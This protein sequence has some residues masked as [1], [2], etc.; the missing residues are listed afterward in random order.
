MK[1]LRVWV[2]LRLLVPL[3]VVIVAPAVV[4]GL[5]GGWLTGLDYAHGFV[6]SLLVAWQSM[7]V[8]EARLL[9]LVALLMGGGAVLVG[10]ERRRW[11]LGAAVTMIVAVAILR[12]LTWWTVPL[13]AALFALNVAPVARVT[14]WGTRGRVLAWIP[15]T[16]LLSPGLV[17][18]A[19]GAGPRLLRVAGALGGLVVAGLWV[20]VDTAANFWAYERYVFAPWPDD[21]VDPRVT[22]IA[23]APAGVK[24]D[25]HDIDIVG[26]RAV[27][28]AETTLQLLSVPLSGGGAP[29]TWPLTPWWGAMEGLAMDSE[30]DP[31]TGDTWFLSGPD[32]VTGVAFVPDS[33]A[34]AWTRVAQSPK[35][36][37]YLHHTYMHWLDERDLLVLFSI[38]TANTR[39][40]SWMIE[41]D[42]PGLR[43]PTLRRLRLADGTR[44]PIFR[45]I[46]WVPTQGKF[47]LAPDF[48][49]RL[50]LAEPGS[51]VVTPWI[52][53]PTL[54]G[55]L[56]W[57]PGLDRLF[58]PL[59]NKPELWIVDPA[60]GGIE[61]FPTQPGVRTV[62]VDVA[63]GLVLTASVL[64]G[65][66]LVQR[67]ADGAVVDRFGTL[68]PM[69]RTLALSSE[70][71]VALL[72][73]WT[74]LYRI[75]YAE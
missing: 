53:L 67:L 43:T 69:V 63:R 51:P 40:D 47:V 7:L 45:D 8:R 9:A 48:G 38:G 22:T 57:V 28:V 26:G 1:L 73:T 74:A 3:I 60:T 35:L 49:E 19:I 32:T 52:T 11:A 10:L 42:T 21:R 24:C 59:P 15:G 72:S 25:F 5:V 68:M 58:V 18:A 37:A 54:N 13:A 71:G 33:G 12:P 31:R 55:R 65:R 30:T 64:T 17:A 20:G 2:L 34:G 29:A 4:G 23:R 50:Y 6:K 44:P 14:R 56:T 16:E 46:A 36:P 62:A 39:E 66:V 75:P 61:V 70:E 27:V 41:L